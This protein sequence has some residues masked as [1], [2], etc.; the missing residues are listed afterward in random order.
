[1]HRFLLLFFVSVC[2]FAN[3]QGV[4]WVSACADKNFCLNQGSCTQGAVLLT[5]KAVTSCS[6]MLLNYSYKIDLDN[7]GSIDIQASNDSISGTFNKGTHKITWR[8]TDNCGNANTCTYF[9]TVKDCQPPNLLCI[10]GLTQ[11]LDAPLCTETFVASTF[12]LSMNDNC[13]PTNQLQ[14]GIRK[15]GSGTGFP[16]ETTVSYGRCDVGTNFVEIWVKDANGLTNSCQN[17]VLVQPN[18][19]GCECNPDSDIR[20]QSCIRTAGNK[21]MQSVVLKSTLASTGGVQTPV[22]K[23]RQVNLTDSCGTVHYDKLP[24][25]GNYRSVLRAE[26]TGDNNHLNG[27]STFDLLLISKHILNIQQLQTIYQI[28]AADVNQSSSVTTF[29]IVEIRKMLLGIY[30]TLPGL[31]AWR[32]IRPVPNPSDLIAFGSVKDSVVLNFSNMQTDTILS[33]MDFI[34]IKY[35]DIN[36]SATGFDGEADDRN[37]RVLQPLSLE[38]QW[39]NAGKLIEIPM[40]IGKGLSL[41]AWQLALVIDPELAQIE[42]V[43]G[44]PEEFYTT[45]SDGKLRALWYDAELPFENDRLFTLKL[46]ILQ[47]ARLSEI[48]SL[49]EEALKPECYSRSGDET[50]KRQLVLQWNSDRVTGLSRPSPNP[51]THETVFKTIMDSPSVVSVDIFDAAG[52]VVYSV[53]QDVEQ[54][55]DAVSVPGVVFPDAGVYGYRVQAG[56]SVLVGKLIRY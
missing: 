46:R 45:G 1:M 13:T 2:H 18:S 14:L 20:L 52:R 7:N 11:G 30:D 9:F 12:V 28:L 35:G 26:R 3:A 22:N 10:N 49:D 25:G 5:E 29:D 32:M 21:K 48:I 33:G 38:N 53:V 42:S 23:I 17:Y 4:Y 50:I 47:P 36:Q 54:G 8:V 39:V 24:F 16:T 37:S 43:E 56:K 55:E 31:K 40:R 6:S 34:G 15:F 44:L 41:D 51:F 19:G 27:V